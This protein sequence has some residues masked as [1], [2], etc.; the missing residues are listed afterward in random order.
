MIRTML[1]ALHQNK[2]KQVVRRVTREFKL[3]KTRRK[4]RM[5]SKNKAI[6][7]TN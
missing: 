1:K 6:K 7:Q 5:R 2:R 3:R 4:R